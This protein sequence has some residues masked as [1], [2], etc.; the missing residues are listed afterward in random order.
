LSAT[1]K[2]HP[3]AG[4]QR[5]D[6]RLLAVGPADLLHIFEDEEAQVSEV[7]ERIV[8]L[9]DGR[10]TVAQIVDALCSEFDVELERCKTD[11]VEFL[12]LLVQR[13]LMVFA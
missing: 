1:P 3:E 9:A 11:T 6:G 2:L 13:Q 8:E 4:V 12:K 7:G 5:A 10:R